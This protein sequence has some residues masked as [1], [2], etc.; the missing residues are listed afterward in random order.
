MSAAF[1]RDIL[2]D[3]F[4]QIGRAADAL[5][6]VIFGEAAPVG[7]RPTV[8]LQSD[9]PFEPSLVYDDV[10]VGGDTRRS[11]APSNSLRA[12]S[13]PRSGRCG[14]HAALIHRIDRPA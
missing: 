12:I 1:D 4:D 3:A 6:G 13:S 8:G 14:E 5:V 11:A 9:A 7:S 10:A 2:L